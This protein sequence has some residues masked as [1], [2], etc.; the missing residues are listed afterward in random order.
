MDCKADYMNLCL[1]TQS[2]EG[3]ALTC[4]INIDFCFWLWDFMT[5]SLE[6]PVLMCYIN[7]YFAIQFLGGTA[8]TCCIDTT[9]GDKGQG[10]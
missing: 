1:M 4:F 5:Q 2:L 8:L 7:S 9:S 6:V 3:L 10:R